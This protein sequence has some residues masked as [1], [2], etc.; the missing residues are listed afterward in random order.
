MTDR[1]RPMVLEDIASV[2]QIERRVQGHPWT[3]QLF[4]DSVNGRDLCW[5]L[6]ADDQVIGYA[7]LK[8]IAGE[9]ELLT[10]AVVPEYQGQ[11]LGRRLLQGVLEQARE[12]GAEQLFLEVRVSN[13]PAILL[14]RSTGFSDCGRRRDYYPNPDGSHEDALV[15]A[16]AV[17]R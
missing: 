10:L 14:Y 15:M 1:L 5:V 3:H 17:A 4:A 2:V 6:V 9:A 13:A 7:V 11:G 16:L 12:A 8:L